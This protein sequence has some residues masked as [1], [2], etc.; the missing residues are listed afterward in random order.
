MDKLILPRKTGRKNVH[1]HVDIVARRSLGWKCTLTWPRTLTF[2][3]NYDLRERKH[4]RYSTCTLRRELGKLPPRRS[5]SNST[6][7]DTTSSPQL[8]SGGP[9]MTAN[10]SLSWR[11]LHPASHAL[12]SSSYVTLCNS[13]SKS[14]AVIF[15]L[16]AHTSSCL[17][18]SLEKSNTRASQVADMLLSKDVVP[19][20]TKS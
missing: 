3:R 2:S 19:I 6:T 1:V 9:T 5:I 20:V 11:N 16:T 8:S 10:P 12:S 13:Q 15:N 7:S 17:L 18:M 4:L 14:K